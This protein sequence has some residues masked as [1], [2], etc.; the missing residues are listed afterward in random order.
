[1]IE[2][3]RS[4]GQ[5]YLFYSSDEAKCGCCCCEWCIAKIKLAVNVNL[6]LFEC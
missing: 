3:Q 2:T 5:E 1:L 4:L 6:P